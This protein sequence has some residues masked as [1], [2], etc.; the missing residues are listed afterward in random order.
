MFSKRGRG[1]C[2]QA[3]LFH[4][5]RLQKLSCPKPCRFIKSLESKILRAAKAE[6]EP[7]ALL[8][9]LG[10]MARLI[11]VPQIEPELRRFNAWVKEPDANHAKANW[12]FTT[13]DARVKF[14]SLRRSIRVS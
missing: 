3:L 9:G 2:G 10:Y 11:T 1:G 14:A 7:G 8:N 13:E 4:S 6:V 12:H 5:A